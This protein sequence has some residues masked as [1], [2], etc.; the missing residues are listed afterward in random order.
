MS[1]SSQKQKAK[2][3][4]IIDT[5]QDTDDSEESDLEPRNATA[6]SVGSPST[7][8]RK[9][10]KSKASKAL[11]ALRGKNEIPQELI[12]HVLDRVKAEG[13]AGSSEANEENVRLALEHLKIMDVVK[14]KAGLGGINKKDMG[15]HKVCKLEMPL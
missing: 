6:S 2:A 12:D 9:K 8:R 15:E 10:K 7:S 4:D 1:S 14:G 13:S 5:T 3:E 11:S